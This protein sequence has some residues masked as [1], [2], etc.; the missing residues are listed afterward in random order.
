[1]F[2]DEILANWFSTIGSGLAPERRN[3]HGVMVLTGYFDDSGSE[4]K[5]PVFVLAG[6]MSVREVWEQF[7]C[8]WLA[9]LRQ[10]PP[11]EY[12][13]MK[14]AKRLQDAFQGWAPEVRDARV[15]ALTEC[16]LNQP[17]MTGMV[18]VLYWDDF[19]RAAAEHPEVTDN[20]PYDMLFHGIMNIA[21][22]L[23]VEKG[24]N[25]QI[26]FVFDE[27]GTVGERAILTYRHIRAMLP[28]AQ[29]EKV[30]GSPRLADDKVV[31]PL[32]AADF[33]AW[34]VRRYCA[35]T[36]E[37]P[38]IAKPAGQPARRKDLPDHPTLARLLGHETIYKI[39]DYTMIKSVFEDWTKPV[40]VVYE[41]D[42]SHDP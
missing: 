6:Y 31:L 33:L 38:F 14:E 20:H 5:G 9:C 35:D 40:V 28:S 11:L 12:F 22:S 25:H 27:Q 16:I 29:V 10:N 21:T 26:D 8:E 13:K 41:L 36:N 7:S 30:I 17:I 1:M 18:F 24:L 4:Q 15:S 19:R 32:Q 37:L 42:R 2:R 3:P 39:Y 23:S 34:Q